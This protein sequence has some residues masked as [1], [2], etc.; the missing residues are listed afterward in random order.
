MSEIVA[1]VAGNVWKILKTVGDTV[2]ADDEVIILEAMKMEMPVY[3]ELSGTISEI[4]V[5]EG[6]AVKDGDVLIILS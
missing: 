3:S 2:N 5:G 1:P 6:T 4:K